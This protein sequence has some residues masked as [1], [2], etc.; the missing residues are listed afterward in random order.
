M[1]RLKRLHTI[2]WRA[3]RSF[4][5][6]GAL[7]HAAAIAFYAVLSLGPILVLLL[8]ATSGLGEETQSSLI[9]EL[10][11]LMGR[12]G[13]DVIR[14]VIESAETD[15]R[16]AN[17]AGWLST[18]TLLVSSTAVFAQLQVALNEVW[19]VQQ[20]TT[21]FGV[22]AWIRKRLLSLGLILST[23]F[24]LLVSLAISSALSA[25][26]FTMRTDVPGAASIAWTIT[27]LVVPTGI[28]LLLFMAVFRYI[29]DA[30]LGWRHVFHGAVVTTALFV[31]GKYLISLYLGT[32]A[33]GSTY[34]AAGSLAV[35]LLWTYYS[36]AIVLFG[37]E[38]TQARVRE[39]GEPIAV[40]E[41]AETLVDDPKHAPGQD[42]ATDSSTV[43]PAGD[44][45]EGDEPR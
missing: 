3:I 31:L 11:H 17:L 2:V 8:W 33:I 21:G 42:R 38:L 32:S 28:Y 29:P 26:L 18:V 30:Q 41:H 37:A 27:D 19:G 13:G 20:R 45:R 1:R 4:A 34:G 35:M 15:F 10:A 6:D 16:L 44:R 36:A 40:E 25:V 14:I 5:A 9:A 43:P 23:C 24:L 39:S 22:W 7:S 12:Q